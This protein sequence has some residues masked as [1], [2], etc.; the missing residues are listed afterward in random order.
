MRHKRLRLRIKALLM[1]AVMVALCAAP[2]TASASQ[3]TEL[4]NQLRETFGLE[5]TPVRFIVR[6]KTDNRT[7]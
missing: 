3:Q 7:K 2:L 4:E 5:G 6:E 1:A